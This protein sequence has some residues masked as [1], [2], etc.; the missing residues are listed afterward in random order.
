MVRS[1][2]LFVSFCFVSLLNSQQIIEIEIP[3][4]GDYQTTTRYDEEVKLLAIN[5]EY[6][7]VGLP[8]IF[9]RYFDKAFKTQ[10]AEVI[11]SSIETINASS[12]DKEFFENNILNCPTS[13]KYT[14]KIASNRSD[15]YMGIELV[16]FV[17]ENN[18][19]KRIKKIT[20]KVVIAGNRPTNSYLKNFASTSVLS[21]GQW[22]KL[23]L[24]TSGIYKIDRNLLESLGVNVQGLNPNHIN[25][26]GNATG[27]LPESN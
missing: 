5:H 18:V 2:I 22:F 25:V 24:S 21:E 7:E 13:V 16:P 19:L 4:L 17:K 11:I 3:W 1:F 9:N 27:M 6:D 23:R 20:F 15:Y 26:Y 8:I 14:S 10:D 12:F